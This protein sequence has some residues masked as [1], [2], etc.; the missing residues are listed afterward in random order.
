M[1]ENKNCIPCQGGIPPLKKAEIDKFLNQVGG[2]WNVKQE[3]ELRK[4]YDFNKY[5]S[6]I[7]F[8]NL[9]ADLAEHQG[10]HPYIHIN[11]KSV[12]IILFTHKIDGLHENDFLMAN[13][14]DHLYS[15]L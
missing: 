12:E 15:K 7:K 4:S 13:K 10:H 14:I 3:K 6:A 5:L 11:Y 1:L 9:V 8:S 2:E